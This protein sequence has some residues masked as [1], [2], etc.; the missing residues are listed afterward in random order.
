MFRDVQLPGEARSTEDAKLGAGRWDAQGEATCECARIRLPVRPNWL[1]KRLHHPARAAQVLRETGL[2]PGLCFHSYV[3]RS[4]LNPPARRA[5]RPSARSRAS[6]QCQTAHSVL[7]APASSVFFIV[8]PQIVEEAPDRGHRRYGVKDFKNDVHRHHSLRGSA[9]RT[10][11]PPASCILRCRRG[12]G[13]VVNF[14]FR[15]YFSHLK[16]RKFRDGS[17]SDPCKVSA[18]FVQGSDGVLGISAQGSDGES[19]RF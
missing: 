2:S 11:T 7:F 8:R 3:P 10:R 4:D 18:S 5:I 19:A 1:L 15:Y 13:K 12:G 9:T 16:T 6:S 14:L 17:A